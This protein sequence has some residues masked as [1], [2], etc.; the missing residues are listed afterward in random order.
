MT[1]SPSTPRKA[2][3]LAAGLGYRLRPLT[4]FQPKPLI[5][6]GGIPLI[7]RSLAQLETWGVTE[8]AINLHW[9]A[10]LLRDYLLARR[11][12]AVFTF[13]EE[14]RLLGTAGALVPLRE[15]VDG[16][17]F[18]MVN[19]DIVWRMP[20]ALLQRPWLA[21]QP[22]AVLWLLPDKGPRTVETDADGTITTYRSPRR[23]APETA[24]FSGVQ[25]V[26]PRIYAYLPDRR[27]ASSLSLVEVYEAAARV[28]ERVMGICSRSASHWDDAGSLSDYLR[29]RRAIR[30]GPA[31]ASAPRGEARFS[32]ARGDRLLF[33]ALLWPDPALA[34]TLLQAGWRLDETRIEMIPPRGSDRAFLRVS[35]GL[36][37]AVYVR[38]GC[39][40]DENR[41]YAGHARL[42]RDAGV[43]VPRVLADRPEARALLLEDGGVCSLRDAVSA[44][45]GRIDDLYRATLDQVV[46]LHTRAT[47]LAGDRALAMEPAF[48]GRLYAWERDLFL[49][50]IVRRRHGV[51]K[52]FTPGLLDEYD[53]IAAALL[54]VGQQVIVHRDLQSTNV[55]LRRGRVTLIDFQGMRLGAA[56]YDLG[57]LLVDPYVGLP[58][59]RREQLLDYYAQR[60]GG[61]AGEETRRLFPY[62]GV[63]RLTQ[64][65]GAYGRLTALGLS[66]WR[67]HI[68][69]A[70]RLL[71]ELA[72]QSGLGEIHRLA[73]ATI[74]RE[75]RL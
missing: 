15:F 57:S 62:G 33:P 59:E 47:Q 44:D 27:P 8:I 71:A 9:Q 42:L 72:E 21:R 5:P 23:G 48:D 11:G 56:A 63:Q 20:P 53:R 50:Q 38:Y 70:A 2:I 52:A 65:L 51:T 31:A 18:W 19:A 30:P 34:P 55:L 69:P 1:T 3:V 58:R 66:A 40:R 32:L 75:Q 13:S 60:V 49:E 73:C 14:P 16:E 68:I 36:R 22:L 64:A 6:L 26:S 17:P 29:L 74:A 45:P 12:R 61:E 4:L 10:D 67:P 46:R 43:A 35:D 41:R 25:I 7:E 28:G 24:T 54:G 39:Q 37:S